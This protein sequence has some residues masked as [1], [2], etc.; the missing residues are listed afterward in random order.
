MF[1]A[2]VLA[3]LA[4][5]F[6]G[7]MW[8]LISTRKITLEE[9]YPR[10]R[11]E[12]DGEPVRGWY[13]V[14]RWGQWVHLRHGRG[15]WFY[16]RTGVLAGESHWENGTLRRRSRWNLDGTV[17]QQF[18]L[19]A[20]GS[21]QYLRKS[22]RTRTEPPWWWGVTDHDAAMPAEENDIRGR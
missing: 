15:R 11:S 18:R 21:T 9:A 7:P 16:V 14:R 12:Q 1:L 13:R 22:E 3:A 10:M 4:T 8:D 19:F 20:I 5:A 2:I 6:G 17:Q